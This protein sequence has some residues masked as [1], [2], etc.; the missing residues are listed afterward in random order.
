MRIKEEPHIVMSI[1]GVKTIGCVV[2][3]VATGDLLFNIVARNVSI[4]VG[5]YTSVI[6][7]GKYQSKG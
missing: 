2:V 4:V 7:V 1:K 5:H 3:S 6:Y